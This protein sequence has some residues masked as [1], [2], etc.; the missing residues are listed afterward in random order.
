MYQ[1][2][3]SSSDSRST[4]KLPC[5][6]WLGIDI[7]LVSRIGGRVG[8]LPAALYFGSHETTLSRERHDV[9]AT[10]EECRFSVR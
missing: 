2:L 9:A 10:L 4:P 3:E 1:E 8:G 5:W 7:I 6:W